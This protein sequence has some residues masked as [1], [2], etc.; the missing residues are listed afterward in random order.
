MTLESSAEIIPFPSRQAPPSAPAEMTPQGTNTDRLSRALADLAVA[1]AEQRA[2]LA[3]WQAALSNLQ[4][5]VQG[6]GA[7][8]RGCAQAL[9]EIAP[10]VNPR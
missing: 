3:R 5:G 6:L 7:S 4:T 9:S 8:L 2:A 10:S 1:Q